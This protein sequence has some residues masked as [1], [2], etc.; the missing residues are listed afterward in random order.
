MFCLLKSDNRVNKLI[1]KNITKTSEMSIIGSYMANSDWS[2]IKT[3]M[4]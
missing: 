2:F 4:I 1:Y 3:Y